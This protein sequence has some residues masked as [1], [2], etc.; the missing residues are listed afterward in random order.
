MTAA[1]IFVPLAL[2]TGLMLS[3]CGQKGELYLPQPEP[4]PEAVPDSTP[5]ATP[6]A[7]EAN[8][9]SDRR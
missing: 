4:A 3:A 1:R 5:A 6:P 7:P 2:A 9:A 8:P